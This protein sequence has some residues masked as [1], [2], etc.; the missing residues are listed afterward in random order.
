[1]QQ[2]NL[3][4]KSPFSFNNRELTRLTISYASYRKYSGPRVQF[5][6]KFI[7][8]Y[9]KSSFITGPDSMN[10]CCSYFNKMQKYPTS[11][12]DPLSE[13]QFID[14]RMSSKCPPLFQSLFYGIF[15]NTFFFNSAFPLFL[16]ALPSLCDFGSSKKGQYLHPLH[17]KCGILTTEPRRKSQHFALKKG[18]STC[19]NN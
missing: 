7:E 5:Q 2:N 4:L 9:L 19:F 3:S 14:T 10:Q 12:P 11:L 6:G 17:L 18:I 13:A 1:M 8:L 15:L 16:A